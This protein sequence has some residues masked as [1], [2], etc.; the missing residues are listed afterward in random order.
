MD[1]SQQIEA[2]NDTLSDCG[3]VAI[4]RGVKPE[5]VECYAEVLAEG[6]IHLIEVPMNSPQPLNSIQKLAMRFGKQSLVGAGTVMSKQQIDEVSEVGGKLIVMPHTD[7]ALIRYALSKKLIPIPGVA[8]PSEAFKAINAGAYVLKL[9]PAE[10]VLATGLK[11]WKAVIPPNIK[12]LPVGGITPETMA[13]FL[14]A[15]AEGFGLGSRLY[16]PG[17]SLSEFSQNVDAFV[18]QWQKLSAQGS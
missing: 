12:I 2:L 7:E 8:T 14:K 10:Q 9:F 17:I 6:G 3:L 4:L 15:G 5:E 11:A 13:P 18:S 1:S 16:R